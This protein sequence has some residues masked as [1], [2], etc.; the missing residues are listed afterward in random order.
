[1]KHLTLLLLVLAVA[2]PL[3]AQTDPPLEETFLLRHVS[4]TTANPGS[5][6]PYVLSNDGTSPW[7]FFHALSAHVSYVSE[8]GPADQ[9]NEVFSTNWF[10]GGVH[11]RLGDRTTVVLRGRIS[12]EPYTI[13]E[14]GY[15][16][17]LQFVSPEG[18]DVLI[19]H[20]RPHDLFGEAAAEIAFRLSGA[21]FVHVYA[22]AVGDPALGAAP[23][24]LRASGVDFAD[25]PFSYD[26]QETFHNKTRVVTA[27]YASK[28]LK[29]EGS[30]FHDAISTGDHTEFDDGDFD[31]QSVRLTLMP[32]PST[33]V[34]V[35]RG[36]LGEDELTK[37]HITSAS[38]GYST[39]TVAA[40][41]LWTR[42]KQESSAAVTAM[43]FE[44]ALRAARSTILARV[45]SVDRPQ[46]L[47]LDR[48]AFDPVVERTS[49]FTV[50]YLLDLMGGYRYKGG[51]GVNVD[52]HTNTHELEDSP[53]YG[54]KPQSIYAFV[55]FR[56]R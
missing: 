38:L 56:T 9:R 33:S 28:V 36:E 30:M 4:G 47:F 14:E 7:V 35:S 21:S 44:V 55:R 32:T 22:A 52:Y 24:E 1:M 48:D 17:I 42:R 20:M 40:T 25:A 13:K 19:D 31:S 2:A 11:G 49:H 18:G 27:G 3:L 15:P 51:V 39:G 50:G 16:Q 12:L 53:N 23:A 34:Q 8:S 29:L 6:V 45:E 46:D 41:A 5:H 10:A 37:R 43:S 26:V 54:H